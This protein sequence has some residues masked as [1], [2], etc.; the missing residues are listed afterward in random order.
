MKSSFP[1]VGA[2]FA[3][4]L[5]LS[6]PVRAGID[7]ESGESG[8]KLLKLEAGSRSAALSGAG[9][10]APALEQDLN[11]AIDAPEK[12]EMAVGWT[13]GYTQ[14]G[15]DR[16]HAVWAVPLARAALLANLRFQGFSD[17]EG[18]DDE[19][20]STGTYTAST[21][22]GGV[23]LSLP[24]PAGVRLGARLEG[25][26]NHVADARSWAAWGDLGARWSLDS[27]WWSLGTSVRNWGLAT[28]SG[29]DA[30]TLP[31]TVQL[32]GA[33]HHGLGSWD[34]SLML[35]AK[36]P[37]DEDWTFPLGLEARWSVL[38]LRA[39]FP[40][41]RDEARPSFGAGLAW[42][43][44]RV[45]AHLGWHGALGIAPGMQLGLTL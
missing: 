28:T 27:S 16:Q 35:D 41:G 13:R 9:V 23:G 6:A 1:T 43:A 10:A 24:L 37:L 20:R 32:G 39:G 4:A 5:L 19:A 45:D 26:S 2:L 44:W 38:S 15:D 14:F 21:F 12:I 17:L 40:L 22:A 25:G 18:Y 8:Y 7:L 29:D 42:D 34:L 30:E 31:L 33:A 11:P 36:R 3:G